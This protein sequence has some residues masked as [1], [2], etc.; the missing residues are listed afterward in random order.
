[1]RPATLSA[2][3]A[4]AGTAHAATKGVIRDTTVSDAAECNSLCG[5][6]DACLTALYH[7]GCRE[8]W[9]FDCAL[10]TQP[11]DT[12]AAGKATDK[13]KPACDPAV[14]PTIPKAGQCT[15]V[16]GGSSTSTSTSTSTASSGSSSGGASASA[17]ATPS[18]TGGGRRVRRRR[19]VRAR[20]R[21]RRARTRPR[22]GTG[23]GGRCSGRWLRRLL[24]RLLREGWG[25]GDTDPASC[26]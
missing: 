6:N 1:M 18:S 11:N 10:K 8:C 24:L 25:W 13:A 3:V 23:F 26:D 12:L 17:S 4:V 2:I 14:L 16:D 21:P 19:R 5:L 20:R 15:K 9:L 22:G 7:S